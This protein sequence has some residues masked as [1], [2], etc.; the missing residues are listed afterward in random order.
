MESESKALRDLRLEALS[1]DPMSFNSTFEKESQGDELR[2]TEWARR[3]ATSH[4][5]AVFVAQPKDGPLVGMAG[6]FSEEGT[7]YVFGMWV[8]P[9]FRK[10][11]L[12]TQLLDTVLGWADTSHPSAD[13]KLGTVRSSLVAGRLYRSRGFVETGRTEPLSHT[14]GTV[15]HEMIRRRTQ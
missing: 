11:G 14:P 10:L 9:N 4:E 3:S 5:M 2:W 6:G 15:W 12:G 7:T 1:M 8:H 13:V